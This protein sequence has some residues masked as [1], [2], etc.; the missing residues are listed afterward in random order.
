VLDTQSCI[1]IWFGSQCKHRE[2]TFSIESFKKY[3]S[4]THC[5]RIMVIDAFSEPAEFTQYFHGWTGDKERR[6]AKGSQS[7]DDVYETLTRKTYSIDV[8]R[9]GNLPENVDATCVELFLSDD[10][11]YLV[12]LMSREDY[13]LMKPWKREEYKRKIRFY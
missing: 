4:I 13:N 12:F 7:A 10:D 2:K 6:L 1:Y 3:A 9:S 8:L 11:F 5:D